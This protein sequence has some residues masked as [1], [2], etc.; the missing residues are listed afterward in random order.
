MQRGQEDFSTEN[1][2][3]LVMVIEKPDT[4]NILITG[5]SSSQRTTL[6]QPLKYKISV[7]SA[8]MTK[9]KKK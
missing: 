8:L 7:H 2:T 3:L 9:K 4:S 6:L 5:K 1:W